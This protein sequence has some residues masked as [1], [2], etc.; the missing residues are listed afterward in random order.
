MSEKEAPFHYR[1][2]QAEETLEDAE[3][4]LK[5]DFTPRSILNRAYYAVFYAALALI[6]NSDITVKTSK[7]AG[8]ISLLDKEFVH[9]GKLDKRCSKIFRRLF[10]MR[11]ESDYKEFIEVSKKEVSELVLW[12][13]NSLRA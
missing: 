3:R 13:K 5:G 6:I 2:K 11:Q 1:L 12:E 10:E 4:M 8:I 9:K 7:H